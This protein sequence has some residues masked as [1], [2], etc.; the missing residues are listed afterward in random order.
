[1]KQP[2]LDDRHRDKDGEISKKHG[3]TMVKTLRG[4]YGLNFAVGF[5]PTDTLSHLLKS[6]PAHAS[7]T[8]LRKDHDAN[9]LAK[10]IAAQG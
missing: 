6:D 10:K 5:A 8:Q 3:N 9:T 4:I 2:G 1:M 7:L